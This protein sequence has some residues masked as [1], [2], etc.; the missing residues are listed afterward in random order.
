MK[1]FG[2]YK[3]VVKAVANDSARSG[4]CRVNTVSV[5]EGNLLDQDVDVIVN[6]C[7]RNIIPWW[8]LPRGVCVAVI[9][10]SKERKPCNANSSSLCCCL[11]PGNPEPLLPTC[12]E[13]SGTSRGSLGK[14]WSMSR[15]RPRATLPG[16]VRLPR[17]R[18]DDA[19]CR[20]PFRLSW[21]W[22]EA[23]AVYMQGLNRRGS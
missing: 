23:I 22:P 15:R 11:S 3:R 5:V 4:S 16:R 7:N 9:Q 19:E 8:L 12:S 18:R 13:W 14:H 21:L 17:P 6:A 1:A 20:R 10:R 2:R